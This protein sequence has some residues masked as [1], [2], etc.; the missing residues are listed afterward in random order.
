MVRVLR[1]AS[2]AAS[3]CAI[4]AFAQA[5]AVGFV[6]DVR[7]DA[8]VA[9]GAKVAFL[10]EVQAD[11]RVVLDAGAKLTVIYVESGTEFTLAGPGEFVLGIQEA[12]ASKGAAPTRR[13]VVA[14]PDPVVVTRLAN[15]ATASIRMRSATA[16]PPPSSR[17]ALLYPRSAT[18]STLQPTLAWAAEPMAEPFT[19]V[20]A[21]ADGKPAWKGTSR[22][23]SARVGTKLAPASRY[24][25]TLMAGETALG[26]AS[27]ETLP[28]AALRR[29]EASRAAAKSFSGRILHAFVL[30]DVG[31]TQE[32]QQAWAT[33]ARER[34]DLPELAALARQP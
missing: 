24:T 26:E 11:T 25:W 23:S 31:A 9:S 13:T 33:L 1:Q 2:L 12:K 34:P 4:A 6:T 21:S 18:A 16:P 30:Q 8:R 7:G 14:R 20:V 22:G 29:V 5:A 28:D 32:A 10:G 19:V 27:F 15:S 3:L 17:P